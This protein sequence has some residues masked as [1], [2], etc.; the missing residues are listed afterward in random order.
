MLARLIRNT[1]RVSMVLALVSGLVLIL[2][3]AYAVLDALGRKI[4]SMPLPGAVDIV[5]YGLGISIA[6]GLPYCTLR[7]GH[8]SV[9]AL[10]EKMHGIFRIIPLLGMALSLL[11]LVVL[12]Y[13]IGITAE[14]RLQTGDEMWM[15]KFKTWPIWI[16]IAGMSVFAGFCQLLLLFATCIGLPAPEKG[17]Q[18]YE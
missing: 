15:L 16:L 18:N 11:F 6:L 17:S 9:P 3:A 7:L 14:R 5:S 12:A 4:F 10:T 2:I 8:V 1:D 13:Q